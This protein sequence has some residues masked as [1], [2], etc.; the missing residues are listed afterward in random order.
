M[1]EVPV[2]HQYACIYQN[3]IGRCRS[4]MPIISLTAACR[5]HRDQ[6]TERAPAPS[7]IIIRYTIEDEQAELLRE[8]GVVWSPRENRAEDERRHV[9]RA[10]W[11]GI[12][13]N[14][15]RFGKASG[16]PVF[17][18][19]GLKDGVS[20]NDLL[21]ELAAIGFKV[22]DCHLEP[23][24]RE[25]KSVI[26][27]GFTKSPEEIVLHEVLTTFL[28]ATWDYAH[29]WANPNQDDGVIKHTVNLVSN[30][31]D[32]LPRFLVRYADGL[33]SAIETFPHE[34]A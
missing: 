25:G 33:W 20:V 15:Y 7:V 27:L 2:Q 1:S 28:F 4:I 30:I 29:V 8:A 12:D 19:G 16:T 24:K 5:K 32:T 3:G 26:V 9:E 14:A 34:A 11:A 21:I 6:P 31:G 17:G 13:P 22:T 10:R 18:E 23:G